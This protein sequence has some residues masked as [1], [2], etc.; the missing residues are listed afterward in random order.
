M[1]KGLQDYRENMEVIRRNCK[2]M[3]FGMEILRIEK[4]AIP[5]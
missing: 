3:M 2:K 5:Q 1:K 4:V